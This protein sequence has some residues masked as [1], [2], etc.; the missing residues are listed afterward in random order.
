MSRLI[1]RAVCLL[2]VACLAGISGCR[3]VNRYVAETAIARTQQAFAARLS[4]GR[5]LFMRAQAL[6]SLFSD[7]TKYLFL[8]PNVRGDSTRLRYERLG[9]IPA[10]SILVYLRGDSAHYSFLDLYPAIVSN[11]I[12]LDF[13]H[14]KEIER[15]SIRRSE[16]GYYLRRR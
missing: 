14:G 4:Q 7:S 5:E 9:A 11:R 15:F 8:L 10:N 13:L 3:Q 6:D 2:F 16:V 1:E 12:G